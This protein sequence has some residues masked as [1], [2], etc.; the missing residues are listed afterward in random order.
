MLRHLE[1]QAVNWLEYA[2]LIPIGALLLGAAA[3]FTVI[4]VIL[5]RQL[6]AIGSLPDLNKRLRAKEIQLSVMRSTADQRRDRIRQLLDELEQQAQETMTFREIENAAVTLISELERKV[7]DA[8]RREL[9]SLV[10]LENGRR[11]RTEF[12][13]T[14][15]IIR[16]IEMIDSCRRELDLPTDSNALP[17]QKLDRKPERDSVVA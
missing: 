14:D 11:P 16:R 9:H 6:K 3:A 7:P 17:Y 15:A 13:S 10:E 1:S 12:S 8:I 4:S 5:R 2:T